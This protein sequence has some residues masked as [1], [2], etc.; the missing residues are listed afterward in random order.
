MKLI[1]LIEEATKLDKII[2]QYNNAI[3]IL[4]DEDEYDVGDVLYHLREKRADLQKQYTK[5]TN[6][7]VDYVRTP[8]KLPD[9]DNEF[10]DF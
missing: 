7:E 3:D 4:V 1:E 9:P 5:L 6:A 2:V 8:I 10:G